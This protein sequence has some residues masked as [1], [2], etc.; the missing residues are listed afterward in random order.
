MKAVKLTNGFGIEFNLILSEDEIKQ[1]EE[2]GFRVVEE[3]D[4]SELTLNYK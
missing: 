2:K 4:K 3:L 1:Y